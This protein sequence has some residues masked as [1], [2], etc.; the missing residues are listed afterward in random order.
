VRSVP[1]WYRR[2]PL[3]GF[4]AVSIVGAT[5]ESV[6]WVSPPTALKLPGAPSGRVGATLTVFVAAELPIA[7]YAFTEKAYDLPFERPLTVV[8]VV[9]T[10]LYS[11]PSLYTS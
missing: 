8:P 5:H 6:T 2:Y 3:S 11:F 10:R 1:F 4:A 9:P 7:L